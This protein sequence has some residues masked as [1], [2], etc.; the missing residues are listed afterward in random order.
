MTKMSSIIV[1]L[2]SRD[3]NNLPK[4][5]QET[6]KNLEIRNKH[7]RDNAITFTEEDHTYYING[8]KLDTSCTSVIKKFFDPFDALKIANKLSYRLKNKKNSQYFGMTG[9]NIVEMW[10]KETDLG[11]ML[12]ANVEF[13]MNSYKTNFPFDQ[14]EFAQDEIMLEMQYF[15]NFVE[16]FIDSGIIEPYRT[17]WLVYDEAIGV[18]G[19]I[20]IVFE[21]KKAIPSELFAENDEGTWIKN[22]QKKIKPGDSG[23]RFWIFDWKRS[24]ELKYKAYEKGNVCKIP[25]SFIDDCNFS[26]Y[27]LQLNLYRTILE[28][29]YDIDIAGMALVVIHPNSDNYKVHLV[30]FLNSEMDYIYKDRINYMKTKTNKTTE[31]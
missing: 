6:L 4:L 22:R 20:D 8:Q 7:S 27:S 10:K 26:S 19:S 24:K 21:E 12:H 25:G 29:N 11:T 15:T 3:R 16:D 13:L 17:E 9:E 30:P 23:R 2:V 14:Y 31:K 28:K 5:V 1:D 18:A